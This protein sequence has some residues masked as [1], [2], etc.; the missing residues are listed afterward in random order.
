M[1]RHVDYR[2]SLASRTLSPVADAIAKPISAAMNS[3]R[4]KTLNAFFATSALVLASVVTPYSDTLAY[5]AEFSQFGVADVQDFSY[6]E[7]QTISVD[8]GGYR[9]VSGSEASAMFVELAEIPSAGTVQS[10]A[11]GMVTKRGWSMDQYSCLVKLWNRES[12]WRVNAHNKSS[13]AYGIPQAL[14][15]DKMGSIASD[16]RT[17]PTTQIT[18]GIGY[19]A[20]RYKT[21]CGALAHSNDIGWY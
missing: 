16:W 15:G 13:G 19:I 10:I 2:P 3:T 12:N 9:V 4:R 18:W 11:L 5:A 6:A 8:R 1:G 21:P 14:P 17:N 20:A 7:S